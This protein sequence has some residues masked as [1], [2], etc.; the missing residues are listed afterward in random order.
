MEKNITISSKQTRVANKSII[1]R[2]CSSSS[3]V[4]IAELFSAI[5][6]EKVTARQAFFI[7]NAMLALFMTIFP[8][9]MSVV[10]R[11]ICLTW[12]GIALLQCRGEGLG[13]ED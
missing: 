10:V 12:A 13:N 4:G 1:D 7:L 9:N 3:V 5:M 2:I 11:L 8:V 6:G